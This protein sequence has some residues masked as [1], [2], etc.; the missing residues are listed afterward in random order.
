VAVELA[1]VGLGSFV[2]G[3]LIGAVQYL[4]AT[5]LPVCGFSLGGRCQLVED[6]L[7]LAWFEGGAIGGVFAVPTGW[8]VWFG[9]MGRR[10]R[11]ADVGKIVGMTWLGGCVLGAMTSVFSAF[12]MPLVTLL[13]AA[14]VKQRPGAAA[15][16]GA[17]R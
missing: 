14:M 4:A 13:I 6:E 7:L 3:W 9:V 10:A 16:D 15:G 1:L 17:G 2:V 12:L 5:R 11:A 8:A